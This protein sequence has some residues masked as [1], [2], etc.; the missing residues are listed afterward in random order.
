MK[1]SEFPVFNQDF[2]IQASKREDVLRIKLIGKDE[3]YPDQ[4]LGNS[5]CALI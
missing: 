1:N 3:F 2:Q 5:N 4:I